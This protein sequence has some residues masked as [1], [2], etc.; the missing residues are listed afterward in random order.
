MTTNNHSFWS[1]LPGILTGIAAVLSAIA[2][3]LIVISETEL[4]K[5]EDIQ[6]I[7]TPTIVPTTM[8]ICKDPV[9]KGVFREVNTSSVYYSSGV[10]YCGYSNWDQ[11]LRCHN[12]KPRPLQNWL[13]TTPKCSREIFKKMKNDGACNC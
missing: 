5:K 12:N 13:E 7:I 3:L 4:L 11:L 9:Q 6:N 8:P 10:S 1:S 2:G